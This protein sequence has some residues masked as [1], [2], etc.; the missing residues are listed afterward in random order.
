MNFFS[1]YTITNSTDTSG[2][3]NI[4]HKKLID[5]EIPNWVRVYAFDASNESVIENNNTKAY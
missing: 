4:W 2:E 1:L 5:S 3:I